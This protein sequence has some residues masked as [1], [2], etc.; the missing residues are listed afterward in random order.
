MGLKR[1]KHEADYW[2]SINVK[3]YNLWGLLPIDL[4]DLW[5]NPDTQNKYDFF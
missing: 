3:K 5:S 4:K 1:T 2:Y